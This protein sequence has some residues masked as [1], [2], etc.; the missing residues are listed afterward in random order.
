MAFPAL[1]K[2][3]GTVPGVGEMLG[4]DALSVSVDHG[5]FAS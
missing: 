4:D 2:P 5:R 3:C 1:A